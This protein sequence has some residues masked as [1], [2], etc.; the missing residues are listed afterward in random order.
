MHSNEKCTNVFK[1]ILS[2]AYLNVISSCGVLPED[3]IDLC[4]FVGYINN[5]KWFANYHNRNI[6]LIPS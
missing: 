6:I 3:M 4:R 5:H 2:I 1:K